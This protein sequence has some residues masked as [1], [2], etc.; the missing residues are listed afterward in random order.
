MISSERALILVSADGDD[1]Q[2][3]QLLKSAGWAAE[4]FTH[5]DPLV[6]QLHKGAGVA[7]LADETL[8]GDNLRP[9]FRMGRQPAVLVRLSLH[10]IDPPRRG[11]PHRT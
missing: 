7:L 1:A 4:T 8:H 11:R 10:R 9:L 5:V 6:E 2:T 3:S